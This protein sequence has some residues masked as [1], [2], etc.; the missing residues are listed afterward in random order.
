MTHATNI[1]AEPGLPFVDIVREFDAP[2]SAVYRAHVEP[3]LFAQWMGPR[4]MKMEDVVLNPTPGG[5]WMYAF[6]GEEGGDQYSF[7]GVFHTVEPSKLI[8]Q[9]F[10]FNLAPGQ[11]GVATLS[12]DEVDGRTR[13]SSHEVYPSVEARDAAVSS[14]MEHGVREGYD[15]LDEMLA[16]A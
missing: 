14:G 16:A 1:T 3:E 13:L 9:T 5:R 10:E 8:I 12:F 11:V 7:F 15:R 6:R 4:T 2:T